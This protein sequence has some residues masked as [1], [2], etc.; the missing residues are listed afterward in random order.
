MKNSPKQSLGIPESGAIMSADLR[1]K[2][3]LAN[4]AKASREGWAR[5]GP[6]DAAATVQ[7]LAVAILIGLPLWRTISGSAWAETAAPSKG[8]LWVFAV[9]VSQYRNSMIDLEFADNDA[10]T[11]A[12]MLA[13]RAAGVFATV[14]T[15]VLVNDQVTRKSVIDGMLSFFAAA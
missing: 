10:Q 11:L 15:K 7:I 9:G 13:Q 4:S 14:N 3:A 5:V 6:R 8:T 2:S 12:A 1:G